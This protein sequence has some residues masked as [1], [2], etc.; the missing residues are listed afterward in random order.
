MHFP[1]IPNERRYVM[2]FPKFKNKA[3]CASDTQPDDWFPDYSGAT[4]R[5]VSERVKVSLRP[6]HLRAR[7]VCM[8]CD[9]YEECLEYSLQFKDLEGIWANLDQY[10]RAELQRKRGMVIEELPSAYV[11][12]DALLQI[13]IVPIESEYQ[14]E[15]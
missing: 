2:N 11:D 6:N 3:L 8:N 7:S 13:G 9:A 4:L 5:S 15:L 12:L 14:D 10:G 1:C